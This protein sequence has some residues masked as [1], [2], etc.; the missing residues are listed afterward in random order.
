[1]FPVIA[2]ITAI[3]TID[4]YKENKRRLSEERERLKTS[5]IELREKATLH[6]HNQEMIKQIA[7]VYELL[8]DETV[9]LENKYQ[10][11][12][13]LISQATY[14]KPEKTLKLVYK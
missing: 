12:H 4:E 2:M 10:T 14:S 13:F 3:D 9:S 7:G 1:M 6:R 8:T 5:L 11:A